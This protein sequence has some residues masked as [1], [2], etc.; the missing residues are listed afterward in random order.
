MV[1]ALQEAWRV[2]AAKGTLLDLRPV[3]TKYPIEVATPDGEV[4]VGEVD[5][6]REAPDDAAADRAIRRVVENGWFV[7]CRE[8]HF[9]FDIYWDTVSEM[10][11]FF[12]EG[13]KRMRDPVTPSYA[14]LE[15]AHRGLT[16]GAGGRVRLRYRRPMLLAV[17]RKA[18]RPSVPG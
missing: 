7:P 12:M 17:Y 5:G 9:D 3:S 13:S 16:S 11:S 10:A 8:G 4:Q 2:L 14:D 15:K 6:S 1:H 18:T